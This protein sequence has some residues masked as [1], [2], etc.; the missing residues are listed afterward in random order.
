MPNTESLFK[1]EPAHARDDKTTRRRQRRRD[2]DAAAVKSISRI[3]NVYA[4]QSVSIMYISGTFWSSY[5]YLLYLLTCVLWHASSTICILHI[6][7]YSM[8]YMH[9]FCAYIKC[10]ELLLLLPPYIIR[11]STRAQISWSFSGKWR[12][13]AV[14]KCE[15]HTNK[16]F[17]R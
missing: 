1:R 15:R 7:R 8:F 5:T 9:A 17:C 4:S 12:Y 2:T 3:S 16:A 13:R 11:T 6:C 14:E 10:R